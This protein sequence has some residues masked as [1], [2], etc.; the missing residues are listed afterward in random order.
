MRR[1]TPLFL[2]AIIWPA[3]SPGLPPI[4][5]DADTIDV[6]TK[7][8]G[9]EI[10][11]T[12][13]V[14]QTNPEIRLVISG[15]PA[16]LTFRKKAR[17]A[18]LWINTGKEVLEGASSY[19]ALV[20]VS[21]K[22][23]NAACARFSLQTLIPAETTDLSWLC[24]RQQ[25]SL[26]AAQGLF[27]VVDPKLGIADLGDGFHRASAFLAPTAKPGTYDLRF[28]VGEESKQTTLDVRRVGLENLILTTAENHRL[29]Y[30][31]LCLILAGLAGYLTNVV[32]NRSRS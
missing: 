26:M 6:T 15:P 10:S 8:R 18:G 27:T 24:N 29:L 7:F 14:E 22:D 2:A 30:G 25:R 12:T 28:W 3:V 17:R 13:H 32:F 9:T 31:L 23:L 20:G 5:L 19:V 16:R 21:E 4:L 1:F 11:V